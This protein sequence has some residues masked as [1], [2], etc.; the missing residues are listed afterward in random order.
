MGRSLWIVLDF[1][2]AA[3]VAILGNIVAAYLQETLRLTD[4]ARFTVVG[5]V[6]IVVPGLLLFVTLKQLQDGTPTM[7]GRSDMARVEVRQK[8]EKQQGELLGPRVG[9]MSG[10]TVDLEQEVAETGEGSR[11]NGPVVDRMTGGELK[12]SQ[13]IPK[14]AKETR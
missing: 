10:G 4:P 9:E 3:L 11:T 2:L 6:F 13:K 5:I 8:V 12:V 14:S 1:A 7:Q